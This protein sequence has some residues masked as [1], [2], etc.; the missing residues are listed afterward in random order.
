MSSNNGVEVFYHSLAFAL[1]AGVN[2]ERMK[3]IGIPVD[4]F[5]PLVQ[6]LRVWDNDHCGQIR[7]R[8]LARVCVKTELLRVTALSVKRFMRA[9]M[10]CDMGFSLSIG[11]K[12][13]RSLSLIN[14][15]SSKFLFPTGIHPAYF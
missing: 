1:S 10:R 8:S 3:L 15:S 14:G 2:G 9:L 6:K 11:D 4:L 5:C 12:E 7:W 13:E